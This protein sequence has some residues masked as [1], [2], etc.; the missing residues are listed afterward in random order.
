M[1]KRLEK[2]HK[3]KRSL[4]TRAL[5]ARTHSS[6]AEQSKAE[7][8]RAS[9]SNQE[10]SSLLE[11]DCRRALT[12]TLS[13][14]TTRHFSS[15]SKEKNMSNVDITHMLNTFNNQRDSNF[16]KRYFQYFSFFLGV[17]RWERGMRFSLLKCAAATKKNRFY[18]IF[19]LNWLTIRSDFNESVGFYTVGM[20]WRR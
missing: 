14:A 3:R 6:R 8:I 4:D 7:Q 2:V 9:A 16:Q 19:M 11:I 18:G 10:L 12:H 1:Q 20:F 17:E 13:H 15:F 5:R